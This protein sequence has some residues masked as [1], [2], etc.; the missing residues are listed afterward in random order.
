MEQKFKQVKMKKV[1]YTELSKRTKT[2]IATIRQS[3]FNLQ[4]GVHIPEDKKQ[5]AIETLDWSLLYESKIKELNK[6]FGI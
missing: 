4:R 3:W 5:I 2:S 1:F 6:K